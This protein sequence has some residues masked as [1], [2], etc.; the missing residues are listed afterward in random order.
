M[1][2]KEQLPPWY[3]HV[4]LDRLTYKTYLYIRPS[5]RIEHMHILVSHDSGVILEPTSVSTR[6]LMGT[7]VRQKLYPLSLYLYILQ[8]VE[9]IAP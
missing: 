9:S 8:A 2:E 7:Y 5:R 3:G 1:F 4:C 6:A